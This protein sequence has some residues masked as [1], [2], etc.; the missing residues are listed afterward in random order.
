MFT[1]LVQDIG[2]LEQ[3]RHGSGG[4]DPQDLLCL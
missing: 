1:G 3:V 2:T 4:G